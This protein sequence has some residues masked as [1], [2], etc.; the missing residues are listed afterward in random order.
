MPLAIPVNLSIPAEGDLG[1]KLLEEIK[2][3]QLAENKAAKADGRDARTI[4][5]QQTI[6]ALCA[7][8]L[9]IDNF[10]PPKRGRRWPKKSE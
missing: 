5:I 1:P 2:K 6:L 8:Q 7:E 4:T 3:R 10:E 9:G